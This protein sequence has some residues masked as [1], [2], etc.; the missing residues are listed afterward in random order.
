MPKFDK[1]YG[2]EPIDWD[3]SGITDINGVPFEEGARGTVPEPTG[4]MIRSFSRTLQQIGGQQ[5]MPMFDHPMEWL[6]ALNRYEF[7][8]PSSN[9]QSGEDG[10]D[11]ENA[12]KTDS[13]EQPKLLTSAQLEKAL[14]AN[15]SRIAKAVAELT[16]SNP[17]A[18]T[19]LRLPEV[20]R[21]EF[22][23]Y[24][25]ENLIAPELRGAGSKLKA[26]TRISDAF[27][28]SSGSDSSSL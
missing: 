2:P 21:T 9:G 6:A 26:Q 13:Q 10:E 16:R 20:Y 25:V 5:H 7:P 3:F 8:Q 4:A 14:T 17:T 22:L 11:G 18:E 28:I 12:A 24:L 27:G 19:F 1:S 15:S 23:Q